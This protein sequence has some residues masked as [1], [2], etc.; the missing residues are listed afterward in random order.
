[1]VASQWRG[2][3]CE[4]LP[5]AE[6][7]RREESSGRCAHWCPCSPVMGAEVSGALRSGCGFGLRRATLLV[8][9]DGL[10]CSSLEGSE[11]W[12]VGTFIR[13]AGSP[14]H[15]RRSARASALSFPVSSLSFLEID[16][17]GMCAGRVS[18]YCPL[19]RLLLASRRMGWAGGRGDLCPRT[20]PTLASPARRDRGF[21]TVRDSPSPLPGEPAQKDDTD[22]QEDASG[23]CQQRSSSAKALGEGAEHSE[24]P[25]S[26]HE[27]GFPEEE[28]LPRSECRPG[29]LG[30]SGTGAGAVGSWERAW[31]LAS[32]GL[33]LSGGSEG[34]GTLFRKLQRPQLRRP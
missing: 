14:A 4:H 5:Q 11:G 2:L 1:M 25:P 19:P 32:R 33:V 30:G 13:E 12:V 23:H 6:G 29:I 16:S 3:W 20:L 18:P 28:S 31:S 24:A 8:F 21:V 10:A 15:G 17:V 7:A 27:R 26:P 34:T 9:P 22:Q